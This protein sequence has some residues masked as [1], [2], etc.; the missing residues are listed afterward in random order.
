[1]FHNNPEIRR[2]QLWSI[3]ELCGRCVHSNEMVRNN[4]KFHRGQNCNERVKLD[5]T[6]M[7][8]LLARGIIIIIIIVISAIK[9]SFSLSIFLTHI[10]T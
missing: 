6:K 4:A 5:S 2:Q 1:M 3:E 10:H 9:Q 8:L 7:E